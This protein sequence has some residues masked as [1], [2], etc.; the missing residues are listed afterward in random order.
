MIDHPAT[1]MAPSSRWM[2][3][4]GRPDPDFYK[5][6]SAMH[7]A[8]GSVVDFANLPDYELPSD[9]R[10]VYMVGAASDETLPLT[11]GTQKLTLRMPCA[12]T[13]LEVRANLKTAQVS[14]SIFTVN[15]KRNGSSILSTLITIDNGERTS[16]TA[17]APPVISDDAW[18]DDDE[19]TV[20]IDQVGD[21][22]AVGLKVAMFGV[23]S[24]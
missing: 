8:L 16:V 11:A 6:F 20:D 1:L 4:D 10:N 9:V 21:G 18:G 15:I 13:G 14:G 23:R 22:T 3:T 7:R 2:L 17:G 5:M 19:F 24:A 12:M